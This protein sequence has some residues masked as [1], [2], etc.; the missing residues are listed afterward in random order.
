[1]ARILETATVRIIY[2]SQI[3]SPNVNVFLLL[4][5]WNREEYANFVRDV[6]IRPGHKTENNE[7]D[8]VRNE[9]FNKLLFLIKI[10][11]N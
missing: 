3:A 11:S 7:M 9:K 1:M 4:L 5:C 10:Y 6:I 2:F 8:H